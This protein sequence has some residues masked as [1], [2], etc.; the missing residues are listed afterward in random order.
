MKKILLFLILCSA[1]WFF[2]IATPGQ[3]AQLANLF[4]ETKGKI[5]MSKKAGEPIAPSTIQ[6][7][8][9]PHAPEE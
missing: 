8:Y 4:Q 9:T 5:L 6:K 3:K 2:F 1:A 7:L